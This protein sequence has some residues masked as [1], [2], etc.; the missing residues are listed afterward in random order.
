MSITWAATTDL[1]MLAIVNWSSTRRSRT[2][3]AL[4]VVPLQVPSGVITVA[5]IP[6]PPVTS[7]VARAALSLAA[8]SSGTGSSLIAANAEVGKGGRL[9]GGR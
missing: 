2:P 7:W 5:D 4:P 6:P 8:R 1:V 3:S 9:R